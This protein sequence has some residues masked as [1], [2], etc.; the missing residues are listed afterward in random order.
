M[1]GAAAAGT[2]GRQ[3]RPAARRTHRRGLRLHRRRRR[4]RHRRLGR[5]DQRGHGRGVAV[6]GRHQGLAHRAGPPRAARGVQRPRDLLRAQRRPDRADLPDGGPRPGRH[7][8]RRRRHGR[9]RRVH[10]RGDRL[11]LRPD[12]P[13]VPGH[14]G[15]PRRRSSTRSPV[16]ARC[17]STTRPSPASSRRDY[18]IERHVRRRG[19]AVLSLVGGKWTTFRALG[20]APEQRRPGRT[21]H[22]TE[23]LDGEARH[24]RRRRLPGQRGRR[25][26]LD[27]G[28]HVGRPRRRPRRRA[29]DPLRD[30]GRG[31]HPLPGRDRGRRAGPAAALH[32]RAQHP[33]TGVH[34]RARADRA[35]RG[36]PHPPHVPGLP[37]P[38]DRAN[39]STKSPTSLSGPLGWD[40]ARRARR[41]A[42]RRR[43]CSGSTASGST[44]WSPDIACVPGQGSPGASTARSALAA[45]A[46]AGRQHE[47]AAGPTASK[48]AEAD[49]RK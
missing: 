27:Q 32:P 7:H 5:P 19:G 38:G 41:S 26:A 2:A 33:R 28:P 49:N 24:R 21:R 22:G 30:P 39:C 18:R 48:L 1:G 36:R 44:A 11:L 6:H 47:H 9:G 43:C 17:R 46:V 29:A 23:G 16:S 42:T 12:R 25:P 40:A 34:G 31:S 37:G 45:G 35:P 4:Q 20:R 15:G 8:R 14:P 3:H 10:R 13:R